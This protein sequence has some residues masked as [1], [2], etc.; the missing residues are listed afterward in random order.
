MGEQKKEAETPQGGNI[1][2]EII[3]EYHYVS[4]EQRKLRETGYAAI[5]YTD[6]YTGEPEVEGRK[7]EGTEDFTLE[8]WRDQVVDRVVY[9]P[10]GKLN[11]GNKKMWESA[12][13]VRARNAR[14]CGKKARLVFAGQEISVRKY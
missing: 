14:D 7:V 4:S 3:R 1:V 5:T 8:R 13:T 9:V 6:H 11:K 10:T 12:G 2:I